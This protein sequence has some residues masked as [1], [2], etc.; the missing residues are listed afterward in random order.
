MI[1]IHMGMKL[2]DLL[3]PGK[4]T[5]HYRTMSREETLQSEPHLEP[6][7]LVGAVEMIGNGAPRVDDLITLRARPNDAAEA[8]QELLAHPE[9]HMTIV[10]EWT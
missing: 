6:R 5:E 10:F 2:Y 1:M 9:R 8:F 4:R 3:T 7:D